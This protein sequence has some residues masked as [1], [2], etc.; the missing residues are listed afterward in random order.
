MAEAIRSLAELFHVT[1]S[2]VTRWVA[3]WAMHDWRKDPYAL[4]AYSFPVAGQ[5]DLSQRIAEPVA[6]TLF[7]AGEAFADD[8]GTVHGALESGTRT[9][10]QAGAVLE[11]AFIR[12]SVPLPPTP[13]GI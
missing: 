6:S 12:R 7:F 9:A 4:G 5:E 3:D 2:E 13:L 1:P 10:Q 8:Y 11:K